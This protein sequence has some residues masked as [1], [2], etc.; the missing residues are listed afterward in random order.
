LTS[1]AVPGAGSESISDRL[2][3]GAL[4]LGLVLLVSVAW[5]TGLFY[6]VARLGLAAPVRL[7]WID[8]LHVYVGLVG[9][10]FIAGKVLRVGFRYRVRGAPN[11][12]RWQRWMSWSLLALYGAIFVSGV[13]VLLPIRG[14]LYG[15][16][17]ELHLMTS[18]W[19]VPPTTWHVWHYRRRLAPYVGRYLGRARGRRFWIGFAL[20][21][22][23][24][25]VLLTQP[26][27]VSQLAQVMG[28]SSWS[29]S[30]L[31]GVPLSHLAATPDGSTLLAAGDR[32]YL[33][34]DGTV[35]S[36]IGFATPNG[37]VPIPPGGTGKHTHS[38]ANTAS[39]VIQSLAVGHDGIYA[40]TAS[41]LFLSTAGGSLVDL[42]FPGQNVEAIAV[43]PVN[44]RTL[45]TAS[46]AGTLRS[47][48]GGHSWARLVG[49]LGQPGTVSSIAY[50]GGAVFASDATGVFEWAPRSGSWMRS[51]SQASVVG[52]AASPDGLALYA[53][54]NTGEIRQLAAG[55]WHTLARPG[56]GHIHNGQVLGQ[57]QGVLPVAGRLYAAGTSEGVSASADGGETWTQLGGGV[58]NRAPGQLIAFRGRLWAP[59]SD[60]L[61]GYV[62]TSDAPASATWW[63]G[64]LAAAVVIGSLALAVLGLERVRAVTARPPVATREAAAGW[65]TEPRRGYERPFLGIETYI[66]TMA[67]VSA[68]P[69]ERVTQRWSPEPP[70]PPP[71]R[72][73]RPNKGEASRV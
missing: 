19:A 56:A 28:G 54:S 14:R 43:D 9:A 30:G 4:G 41:G 17:L 64:L 60:G 40:G 2:S 62:L 20:A 23:P 37:F 66:A 12:V 71:T 7:A 61:Y 10:V 5:G 55:S 49:G 63:A 45:W 29:Q 16:L 35:W 6:L 67:G 52:L 68:Q 21:M 27:A 47:S 18:V 65:A 51:S 73:L 48:D 22:A 33:S 57:L 32:L 34:R 15:N 11:V 38:P 58:A 72:V 24:A 44:P 13:L 26:R 31:K 70:A 3:V 8:G 42:G 1:T 25:L 69:A 50:M 53:A 39:T 59:T 46:T 36:T